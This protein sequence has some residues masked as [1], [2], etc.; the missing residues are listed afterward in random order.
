[1]KPKA[2]VSSATNLPFASTQVPSVS[3]III[4]LN[5]EGFIEEAIKSVLAQTCPSW[6]LLLVDDGSTDSSTAIAR[7]YASQFPHQ[8]RYLE[9]QGHK[10]RGMSASRN[11]GIQ[12]AR[13]EFIA[14]LDADDVYLPQKL[15]TQIALLHANPEAQ[16]VYGAT[17]HW[18]GWTGNPDDARRDVLR[19]LG[20]PANTLVTPPTMLPKFLRLTAQT[21]GIC[22]IL[23]RREAVQEVGGFDDKFRGMY[24]DQVFIYKLMLRMS[25][26]IHDGTF[27][28]YRQHS[29]SH[30]R[31]TARLEHRE[32]R[33]GKSASELVFL[34]WLRGYL[35]EHQVHDP[36]L[37]AALNEQ[38]WRH[39]HSTLH[40][41]QKL[42]HRL[43]GA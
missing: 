29:A 28:F 35:Q 38:L 33:V 36:E 3:V 2:I 22:G 26:Y 34:T 11:L 25:V 16:M 19:K 13:G 42:S 6:E 7:H 27:D 18:Y 31:V 5:A 32:R 39:H 1:M 17:L 9:H 37:W 12:H 40:R 23:V 4:F 21:P 24:E 15:E 14:F 30:Q 20:V 43:L 8:I 41:L 10:N